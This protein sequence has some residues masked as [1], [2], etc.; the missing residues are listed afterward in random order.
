MEA[1][2]VLLGLDEPGEKSVPESRLKNGND[3]RQLLW[4]LIDEDNQASFYRAL[5]KGMVDGNPPYDDAKRRAEH[6]GWECNLNFNEGEAIMDSSAVP[7]YNLFAQ[8]PYY[9]DVRT[10]YKPDDPDHDMWNE[11]ICYRFHNL[12]KRWDAFDWNVQQASYWMRLHGIGPCYFDKEGD[13]RFRSLETGS[14]LVP[15]GSPSSL[16]NRIPYIAIRIPYRIME[17]YDKIRD[18]EAATAA[19]RNVKATRNAIKFGMRNMVGGEQGWWAQPWERYES[20]LKNN[21]LTVSFTDGDIVN[22]A[23]LLVR[24]FSGKIS[25]F[26][27]TEHEVVG[28]NVKKNNPDAMDKQILFSDIDCYDSYQQALVCFFQNSGD[29]TWH[30]VR[31]LA[32]KSFKHIE[33]SNRLKCQAVNRAFLDSS[34]ILQ[35]QTGRGRERLELAVWGAI[36]RLPSGAELK[37]TTVQGGTDGVLLVDRMLTNHLANNIGQFQQRT[38]SREDGRGEQPTATQVN[39]QVSKE[40][41]LSQG[42]IT[43]FYQDG[44]A[45]YW[46]MFQRAADP[47]TSDEEAKRFQKECRDDGVP[48]QALADMEYVR[49]SRQSGYGSPQ[50]GLLKMQQAMPLVP[51]FPEDGKQ[52]W[53]EHTVTQIY[54]PEFTKDFVPRSHIPDDQDWQASVENGLVADGKMPVI[55]EGQ[56]DVIH[57]HSHL[58]DARETLKPVADQMQT[59]RPD[60]AALQDAIQYTTI[61]SQHVEAHLGRMRQDPMRKAQVK[62]FEDEFKQL[63]SFNS[64]LYVAFRDAQRQ[65]QLQAEQAQQASSLS[66]LDQAK[67]DSVRTG[68]ALAAAKTQAQIRNQTLKTIQQMRLKAV[69]QGHDIALER[70]DQFHSMNLENIDQA[71]QMNLANLQAGPTSGQRPASAP[72][73]ETPAEALG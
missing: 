71:H 40:A 54:G 12:L 23:I 11:A 52:A 31:G 22:C 24:E 50:M 13:W 61:M 37:P 68:T 17:L 43:L 3:A 27:F 51:M 73:M 47:S 42:Q 1:P 57:V 36:A 39:Q 29:G 65:Q 44:D 35:T 69:K 9:A 28:D 70:R 8:V 55:S 46:Q 64:Q 5:V 7:Y 38:L 33:V 18:P 2:L 26:E 15:K 4:T 25:K 32:Q 63:L 53:L 21:E 14:V 49:M 72:P 19:G 62:M 6:R 16:D 30:S 60:P 48:K 58:A 41:A 45:L 66:A 67:V 59:G 10:A 20:M 34:L 56:E